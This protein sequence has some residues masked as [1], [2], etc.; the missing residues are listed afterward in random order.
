MRV[1]IGPIWPP[2]RVKIDGQMMEVHKIY[3]EDAYDLKIVE[4]M[5]R[6]E[7]YITTHEKARQGIQNYWQWM[8]DNDPG[9][10]KAMLGEERMIEWAIGQSDSFGISSFDE[11]K[12]IIGDNPEEEL[13]CYDGNECSVTRIGRLAEEMDVEDEDIS[14][15]YAYRRN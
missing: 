8:A 2:M 15:I 4:M 6:T 3:G 1:N 5:D 13:G 12:D 9:E 10:L 14:E 11:F 7:W